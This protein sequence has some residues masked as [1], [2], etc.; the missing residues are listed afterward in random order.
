MIPSIFQSIFVNVWFIFFRIS[1]KNDIGSNTFAG[2]NVILICN[3]KSRI[4]KTER[5]KLL[6][7]IIY[8][9][10]TFFFNI[11]Q[12]VFSQ[13]FVSV[14]LQNI[15]QTKV[16]FFFSWIRWKNCLSMSVWNLINKLGLVAVESHLR[17]RLSVV[18]Y[19]LVLREQYLKRILVLRIEYLLSRCKVAHFIIMNKTS[20]QLSSFLLFMLVRLLH[21][22][23]QH[24]WEISYS[25][26]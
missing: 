9:F 14:D 1:Q 16:D 4:W 5:R 2:V 23:D 15:S 13:I 12:S 25:M 7:K 11:L 3:D 17:L 20:L 24:L 22:K 26:T 10:K 8:R 19:F 18:I 21:S 6:N